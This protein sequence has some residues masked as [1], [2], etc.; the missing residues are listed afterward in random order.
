MR[1]WQATESEGEWLS[2]FLG[3][4]HH[5]D[6]GCHTSLWVS[7]PHQGP[8]QNPMGVGASPHRI[9]SVRT[10]YTWAEIQLCRRSSSAGRGATLQ[11]G[12]QHAMDEN[13]ACCSY[14]LILSYIMSP[15]SISRRN[16]FQIPE[17]R[18]RAAFLLLAPPG[19]WLCCPKCYEKNHSL[20]NNKHLRKGIPF[21][22]KVCFGPEGFH[23]HTSLSSLAGD[24]E[25]AV[26]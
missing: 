2:H 20:R 15:P 7:H 16:H 5:R 13:K 14:F 22:L 1:P 6:S 18:K 3:L 25:L 11:H 23:F 17:K 10:G 21:I 12:C 24:R 26:S 8:M 9:P 19:T 4:A